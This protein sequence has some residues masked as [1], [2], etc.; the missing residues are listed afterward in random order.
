MS[1]A[2]IYDNEDIPIKVELCSKKT[3]RH[4]INWLEVTGLEKTYKFHFPNYAKIDKFLQNLHSTLFY[5]DCSD[6]I[7]SVIYFLESFKDEDEIESYM[8]NTQYE[9]IKM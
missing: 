9:N 3:G 6:G 2:L 4:I 5:M 1:K 7:E 8:N